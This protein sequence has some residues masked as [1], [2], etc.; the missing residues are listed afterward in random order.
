MKAEEDIQD[1]K[2]DAELWK[3]IYRTYGIEYVGTH[4][5]AVHKK[6]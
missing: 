4:L 3:D 5:A 6:E 2:T 1:R